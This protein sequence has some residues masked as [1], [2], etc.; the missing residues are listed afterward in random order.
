VLKRR[1][2]KGKEKEELRLR[3]F[4]F[5]FERQ[6][7]AERE[8]KKEQ[9][10]IANRGLSFFLFHDSAALIAHAAAFCSAQRVLRFILLPHEA[11]GG[12]EKKGDKKKARRESQS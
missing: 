2:R 3:K 6:Q 11:R 7:T 1:R 9:S 4:F 5:F 10:T 8:S 12:S